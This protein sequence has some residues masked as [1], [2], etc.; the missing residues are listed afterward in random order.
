MRKINNIIYTFLLVSVLILMNINC[1]GA[2]NNINFK[3]ITSEDGLSQ[4]TV[5]TLIQDTNGYIWIGTNDGLNRYNGY[6]FKVYKHD[7]E[8]ENSIT[9]NYI[10][11]IKEDKS[12]NIWV[13]TANGLSKINTKDD[14]ITNYNRTDEEQSLS[15]YNIGDILVTKSGKVL[16]GTPDG[17]NIYDE[18]SDKSH[19]H[20]QVK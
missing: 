5:E 17:L 15:H 8:S 2:Y 19:H 14:L 10:V 7:E 1:V 20:D 3:N 13:G 11:D 9:N 16:V 18:K 12:G 6:D 4:A